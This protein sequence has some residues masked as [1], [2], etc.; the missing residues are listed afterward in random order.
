MVHHRELAKLPCLSCSRLPL[1]E[2]L[3]PGE[4]LKQHRFFV[5]CGFNFAKTHERGWKDGEIRIK[6]NKHN[7]NTHTHTL[8][9]KTNQNN[10]HRIYQCRQNIDMY[11]LMRKYNKLLASRFTQKFHISSHI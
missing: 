9:N 5:I 8:S 7:Q 1:L 3:L 6:S 4:P 11:N 2:P 10:T